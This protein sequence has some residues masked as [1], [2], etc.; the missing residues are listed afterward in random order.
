VVRV[1]SCAQ[2]QQTL[3]AGKEPGE[4]A[5]RVRQAYVVFGVLGLS[6]SGVEHGQR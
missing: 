3:K 6:L 2:M 4:K 1:F 5:N